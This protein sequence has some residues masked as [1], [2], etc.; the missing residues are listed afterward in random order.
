MSLEPSKESFW[1]RVL[2]SKNLKSVFEG[3]FGLP[4]SFGRL[5]IDRQHSDL[6]SRSEKLFGSASPE[7][8]GESKNI[9]KLMRNFLLRSQI[10]M[11]LNSSPYT[12]ALAILGST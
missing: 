2:G 3:A 5:S 7:T 8:F 9:E 1:F 4:S 10:N 6:I 12:T 11:S